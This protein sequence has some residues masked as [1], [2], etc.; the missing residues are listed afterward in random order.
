MPQSPKIY[1][2]AAVFF[3]GILLS[4]AWEVP[5][6]F[7]RIGKGY[8]DFSNFYTAGKILQGGNSH[9]LYDLH[10][11]DSVQMQF[12]DA[13]AA[14]HRALP[15]P[16]PPFEA[17]I[18]LPFSYL[19][20]PTAYAVWVALSVLLVGVTAAF[21]RSRIPD[22]VALPPWLYYP[23]FFS[24]Y[25]IVSG[26]LLG[27]DSALMLFFFGMVSVY[28]LEGKDFSAGCFL[29][30]ALI[31][32]QLVL[33][34]LL[35]LFLKKQ[36]RTLAG[37]TMVAA[38]LSLASLGVVGWDGVIGYPAYL[39]S[40]NE[41][42][43][44]AGIYPSVMPSL[45]GLVQGWTESPHSSF[46]LNLITGALSLAVLVWASL[47]WRTSA[48]RLSKVYFA[49][50][51][52]A[53]VATLLAGYHEFSYDLSL[54]LPLVL[55]AGHASL[56]DHELKTFTRWILLLGVGALLS[57]PLYLWLIG[58]GRLNLMAVPA[59]VL[60]WGL[61]RSAKEWQQAEIRIASASPASGQTSGT[62]PGVIA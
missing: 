30:L 62:L 15:Y 43:S 7:E 1:R 21:L 29:G 12:S 52:V 4:Y 28:W 61:A 60:A 34:L 13:A 14:H 45:R 55:R 16:R 24:F 5:R 53:L 46:G 17:L 59:L 50:M 49:G 48:P 39:R 33:P 47:N 38:V 25:P 10:L 11:Q 19:S 8:P 44:A 27:Q 26:F 51:S 6:F 22:F 9:R 42:G 35:I 3:W 2:F 31:K 18:F 36:F 57:L 20:Y 37:F 56:H 54:L 58:K 41:L 32:F 23:A 40:L